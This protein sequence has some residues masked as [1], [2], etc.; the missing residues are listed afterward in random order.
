LRIGEVQ[1][2]QQRVI[3]TIEGMPRRVDGEAAGGP[4]VRILVPF[5]AAI[6]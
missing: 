1:R 4:R 5:K 2:F 6:G 3:H